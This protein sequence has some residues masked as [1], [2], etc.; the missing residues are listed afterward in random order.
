[1]NPYLLE[2]RLKVVGNEKLGGSRCWQLLGITGSQGPWRWM[3]V[4]F[5][6]MPF[7]IEKRVSVSAL[8]CNMY[9]RSVWQKVI[10]CKQDLS[11][12]NAP[13]YLRT[14]SSEREKS[15]ARTRKKSASSKLIHK[16]RFK[17]DPHCHWR[18][19]LRCVNIMAQGLSHRDL[20][21]G[22]N[23]SFIL[24]TREYIDAPNNSHRIVLC[25]CNRL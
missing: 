21:C 5:L 11:T 7:A 22:Q 13:I 1:M 12:Y 18:R 24:I 10:R 20:I 2:L 3:S 9:R 15:V 8:S 14:E 17:F 19:R 4:F 16:S 23:R 6:N 25:K